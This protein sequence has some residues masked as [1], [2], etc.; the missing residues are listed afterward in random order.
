[1]PSS[2][3]LYDSTLSLPDLLD[4][5]MVYIRS[6]DFCDFCSI[7][8]LIYT[9]VSVL[10]QLTHFEDLASFQHRNTYIIYTVEPALTATWLWR[11]PV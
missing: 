8:A 1:M 7:C 6:C 11:D 5:H 4:S 10:Y 9:F 3:V 2:T